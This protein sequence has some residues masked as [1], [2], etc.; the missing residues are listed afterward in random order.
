MNDFPQLKRLE[1]IGIQAELEF[2]SDGQEYVAFYV[3]E[4][5]EKMDRTCVYTFWLSKERIEA[6][7]NELQRFRE[8]MPKLPVRHDREMI[9]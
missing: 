3:W 1:D 4:R 8:M 6:I 9:L 2:D 7:R 5:H